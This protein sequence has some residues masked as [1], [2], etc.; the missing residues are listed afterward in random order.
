VEK[1]LEKRRKVFR[2]AL[3]TPDGQI[4]MDLL[5]EDFVDRSLFEDDP[6]KMARRVAQHDLVQ[7]MTDMARTTNE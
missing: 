4:M 1:Q 3:S 2:N 5:R 7:Y 6:L